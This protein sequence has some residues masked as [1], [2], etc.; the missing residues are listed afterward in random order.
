[1]A[2]GTLDETIDDLMD[3][4]LR[5]VGCAEPDS[6]SS[7][8]GEEEEDRPARQTRTDMFSS[9]DRTPDELPDQTYPVMDFKCIIIASKEWDPGIVCPPILSH[10]LG[11]SCRDLID[12]HC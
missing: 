6:T 11:R 12:T 8:I 4:C 10:C 9:D 1:M 3:D 5:S 7:S 2:Y